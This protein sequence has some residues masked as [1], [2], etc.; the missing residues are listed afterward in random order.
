[1]I[2]I[3]TAIN[4]CRVA[5]KL[6]KISNNQQLRILRK[7]GVKPVKAENWEYMCNLRASIMREVTPAIKAARDAEDFRD[8]GSTP[9]RWKNEAKEMTA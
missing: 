5:R 6:G 1:M 2:N 7:L 8:Y 3:Q 4:Q 9:R